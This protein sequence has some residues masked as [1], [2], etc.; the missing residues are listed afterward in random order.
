MNRLPARIL[1]LLLAPTWSGCTS[2]AAPPPP[3]LEVSVPGPVVIDLVPHALPVVRADLPGHPGLAFVLDSGAELSIV[4][5]AP[6]LALGLPL[7]ELDRPGTRTG[8]N[9]VTLPVTE[10]ILVEELVLDGVHVEHLPCIVADADLGEPD[11]VGI[12]GQDVLAQLVV[13]IDRERR[14]LHALPPT[15]GREAISEY[16]GEA[17]LGDGPWVVVVAEFDPCPFLTMTVDQV[18]YRLEVDT[19]ATATSFPRSA[20]EALGIEPRGRYSTKTI[21]GADEGHT[22]DVQGLDLFGMKVSGEFREGALDHGLLGMDV[23]GALVVVLD[24]PGRS[25][26]LHNRHP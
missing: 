14:R 11:W 16:L 6:A 15:W 13:V 21:T 25:I 10:R 20:F 23:L 18:D 1:L 12:L 7:E 19:G 17:D 22:Y 2:R 3:P 8:A 5:R 24:G 26:W 9:G 4:L